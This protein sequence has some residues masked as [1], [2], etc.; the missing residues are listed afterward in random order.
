MLEVR[1]VTKKF[2]EFTAVEAMSFT[3]ESGSIYGLVGYN[4]AG[5]TT[6]LK[7]AA[8]IYKPEVGE[9]L[10]DGEPVFENNAVKQQLF[11]V[12]D[13]LYFKPYA[14]LEQTKQ[15]YKAYYPAFSE[16]TFGKLLK[17]FELDSRKRIHGF[18]K[19][20]QR[21]A[22]MVLAL[23]TN[24]AV[25]LLDESFDGLDPARRQLM[26]SM[27]LEYAADRACAVVL[28]SHNLH[29]L[30]DMCDRIGLI[31]GKKIVFDKAVDALSG[32]RCKFRLVFDRV[33]QEAD[34]AAVPHSRLVLD[35]KIVTLTV[36][37]DADA[38]QARLSELSPL[39]IERFPQ[40]VEEIF[41]DE[42][43]GTEYD[44]KEIFG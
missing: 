26:R 39:L 41:L 10:V 30:G 15:F 3:V 13:D 43:E 29:E 17:V 14:T 24:P 20:M 32:S 33:L 18:S 42:M 7:T 44:F 6:I 1:N 23:S 9:V 36:P 2:G 40:S 12:P 21:Q 35:G 37:G 5:K 4:G 31:N 34:F 38:A 28:S 25:L 27:L 8:G 19:G 16:E 11:F 22:E